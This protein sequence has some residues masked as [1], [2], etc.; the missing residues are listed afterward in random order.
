LARYDSAV[1]SAADGS[2]GAWY[3]RNPTLFLHYFGKSLT[4]H[5]RLLR[6]WPSLR[7]QYRA[8]LGYLVS[9]DAWKDTFDRTA[10]LADTAMPQPAET[11]LAGKPGA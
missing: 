4:L 10:H 3:K 6:H 2:G 11:S 9:Q 7:R 1:V 5:A 8:A